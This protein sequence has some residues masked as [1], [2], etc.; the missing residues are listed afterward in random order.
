MV[1]GE[2]PH[3]SLE[4]EE[5]ALIVLHYNATCPDCA[6]RARRTRRLDWFGRIELSTQPSPLGEVPAGEIVV[7]DRRRS[8]VF[9]GPYAT[10]KVCLQVPLLFLC[11]LLLYAPFI[12]R[13]AGGGAGGCNGDA[14]EIG[15]G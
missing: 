9:T 11:G 15:A 13:A 7:V 3:S 1:S 10:R 5:R 12:R 4:V 2:R 14:C 8:T 6:R